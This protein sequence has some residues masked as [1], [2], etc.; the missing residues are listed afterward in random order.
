MQRVVRFAVAACVGVAVVLG[1]VYLVKALDVLG[2][3]AG[4][5]ATQN[6]DDRE[7]GGGNSLVVDKRAL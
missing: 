2:D 3:E 5:N 1:L 4:V 7:F 6:Y